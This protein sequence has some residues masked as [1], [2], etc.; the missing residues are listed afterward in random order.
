MTSEADRQTSIATHEIRVQSRKDAEALS[1]LEA[2]AD[3]Y[4][5]LLEWIASECRKHKTFQRLS[6]LDKINATLKTK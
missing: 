6:T 3:R 2:K 4:R 5:E 1:A